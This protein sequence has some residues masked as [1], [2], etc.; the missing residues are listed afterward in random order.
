MSFF[1][2]TKKER[3]AFTEVDAE[4]SELLA[5]K[6][7]KA[8]FAGGCFWCMEGPFEAIDG[9]ENTI[10]GFAGGT[11]VAPTYQEVVSGKTGHRE[12]VQVFFDPQQVSYTTLVETFW[13]QIDPTDPG[14]QFADRGSDYTTAIFYHNSEQKKAAE[15]QRADL[16][17]SGRYQKPIVTEIL[18]FTTFYPAEDYHQ[19]FYQKRVAYYQMYK[20]GSGR[21]DYIEAMQK[22]YGT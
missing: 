20:K 10:V 19:Q 1:S 3:A 6:L 14:G 13:W 15:K 16:E 8:T 11:V 2:K 22:K 18:P 9:V 7:E 5:S 17:K 4:F 21:E 12:A